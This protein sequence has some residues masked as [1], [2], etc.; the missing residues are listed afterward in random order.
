MPADPPSRNAASN[1]Q[2]ETIALPPVVGLRRFHKHRQRHR[3]PATLSAPCA[4]AAD[5]AL[6]LTMC[7]SH[8]Q[9]KPGFNR[10]PAWLIQPPRANTHPKDFFRGGAATEMQHTAADTSTRASVGGSDFAR[11]YSSDN[12]TFACLATGA[13]CSVTRA[14]MHINAI[15]SIPANPPMKNTTGNH[16]AETIG[17]LRSCW[18]GA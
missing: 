4:V 16:Q 5:S 17:H 2:I 9:K 8:S 3:V 15:T 18:P 1:H 13:D 7:S 12:M 10:A 6:L 14:D 11:Q